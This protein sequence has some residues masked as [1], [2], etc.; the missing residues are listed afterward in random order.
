MRLNQKPV[1]VLAGGFGTRLKSVVSDVPKPLAPVN[2]KP[3]I[4]YLMSHLYSQGAR[5]FFFLLH[6]EAEVIK[7]TLADGSLLHT[8]D[9]LNIN[10]VVEREPL[11]TG[12]AIRNALTVFGIETS[13]IVV[14]ADTWLGDGLEEIAA[15]P[16]NTIAS[17]WVQ[18]CSRYGALSVKNGK[19]KKFLEKN[20]SEGKGLIN[21][22]LYHLSPG[23]FGSSMD[24]ARFSLESD[25]FPLA[26]AQGMLSAVEIDAD[27]IDIGIPQ[28]Y[29]K[30][31]NWVESGRKS[32]L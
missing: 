14:N 8:S 20:A 3:F 32:E 7:A 15:A 5:N 28:D 10:S 27:F 17:V 6:Y 31:C 25:V 16:P 23:V 26:A 9:D 1:L 21:A 11:G 29:L 12:G 18:D 2:G 24:A 22:G 13:F 4:H 19:I 30:F